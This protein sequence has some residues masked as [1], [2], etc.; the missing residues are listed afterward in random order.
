MQH[1]I[2]PSLFINKNCVLPGIGKLSIITAPAEADY[3]HAQ[4][5]APVQQIVF[6]EENGAENIFNEFSA[7]SELI[8]KDLDKQGAVVLNGIGTFTKDDSGKINF[9]PEQIDPAFAQTV[10]AK[11]VIRQDAQHAILVGDKET[12]NTVMTDFFSEKPAIKDHWWIW[13]IILF[14]IGLGTIMFYFYQNGSTTLGNAISI[15]FYDFE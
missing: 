6:V 11:R 10:V 1:L 5:K 8:W 2:A 15:E 3:I 7:L 9:A 14:I 4:I 12:T 13:A